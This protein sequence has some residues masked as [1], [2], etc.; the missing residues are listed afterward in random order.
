VCI[1]KKTGLK[2]STTV[3]VKLKH[4]LEKRQCHMEEN[5]M[6]FFSVSNFA[7]GAIIQWNIC[8]LL[9][10]FTIFY[11]IKKYV[12]SFSISLLRQ[13]K[14]KHL[15]KNLNLFTLNISLIIIKGNYSLPETHTNRQTTQNDCLPSYLG[16]EDK[17]I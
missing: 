2:K 17:G 10:I 12:G 6:E 13:L 16:D 4:M 11:S 7:S 14:S 1:C 3:S 5:F 15:L 9:N 8:R